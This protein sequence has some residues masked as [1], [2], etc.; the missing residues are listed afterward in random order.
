MYARLGW[1]PVLS[2]CGF[3]YWMSS[4]TNIPE[5][6]FWL[7]PYA[8]KIMHGVLYAILSSLAY[9]WARAMHFTP[10]RALLLAIPLASIYGITDEWHQSYVPGRHPDVYDW[11]ADTVGA[12]WVVVLA[13]RESSRQKNIT[14]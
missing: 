7:P 3:I 5:P 4:R 8:D 13:W 6:G 2:W 14:P 9:V 10:F 12:A 11:I 1:I